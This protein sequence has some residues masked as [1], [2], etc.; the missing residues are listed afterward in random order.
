M[1]V[2]SHGVLV[3]L[4]VFVG[5]PITIVDD[6]PNP[7]KVARQ[8]GRELARPGAETICHR[9]KSGGGAGCCVENSVSW[10]TSR[11]G[12]GTRLQLGQILS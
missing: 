9:L 5:W 3:F 8:V 11:T 10:V 2:I 7:G 6:G 4:V 12:A 1:G